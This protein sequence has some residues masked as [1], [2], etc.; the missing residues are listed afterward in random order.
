MALTEDERYL[1]VFQSDSLNIAD[2][3]PLAWL[4]R[5]QSDQIAH[6]RGPDAFRAILSSAPEFGVR[7]F[8]LGGTVGSLKRL[9][10]VIAKEYPDALIVGSFSP[11]F[12]DLEPPDHQQ[13][14]AMLRDADANVVW[15][16]IGTPKQDYEVARIAAGHP[17]VVL[18]VG[19]A[20]NFVSGDVVEA[21]VFWRRTGLEWVYR[22]GREPRRL[23]RRY[24][25]G[26][27]RFLLL[28]ARRHRG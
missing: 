4:A 15:V 16:G 11:P 3:T 1:G 17:A 24:V 25:F 9:E 21:P 28:A 5:R 23:W 20:F 26:N 10:A 18:A 2:G 19:A 7:H 13:I 27:L 22:F 8:L 14:D 12:R 6:M